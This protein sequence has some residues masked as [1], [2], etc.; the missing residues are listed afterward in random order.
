MK[1]SSDT[2]GNQT[3][4]LPT[5]SAVPQPTTPP[6]APINSKH[7]TINHSLSCEAL[8]L[9]N[10]IEKHNMGLEAAIIQRQELSLEILKQLSAIS[11]AVSP[12]FE[13]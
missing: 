2:I 13:V 6:R 7:C 10:T 8:P 5:C 9:G 1:N 11:S 12:H 4:D 3:R